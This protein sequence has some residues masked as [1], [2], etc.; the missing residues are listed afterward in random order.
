[1]TTLLSGS[2][3]AQPIINKVE[4]L[5][6]FPTDEP[7]IEKGVSACFA[8]VLRGQLILAGG[9]NF[10]EVPAAQKGTKRFYQGIYVAA[11]D[12]SNSL[13]WRRIGSLPEPLAYGVSL[14]LSDALVL[15]GGQN[16]EGDIQHAYELTLSDGKAE[17]HSL[18][19][20]PV[21]LSN[22][23]GFVLNNEAYVYDTRH[24]VY[25]LTP[26]GWLPAFTIEG[27]RRMQPIAATVAGEPWLWGGFS[28][29]EGEAPCRIH[30]DGISVNNGSTVS[31][32]DYEASLSGASCVSVSPSVVVAT[33]GVNQGVFETQVNTPREGYMLHEPEW[34]R[35]CPAILAFSDGRWKL[36]GESPL[37][38]LAGS[39]MAASGKDIYVIGGELKPGI[40]APR[41]VRIT[42]K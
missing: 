32:P 29:K 2:L 36:I 13:K 38:A 8:G 1:M 31:A 12:G 19:D 3:A 10:P 33:G 39:T 35:F 26:T 22:T 16:A 34:Y 42:L 15:V 28:P 40:R 6:G 24:T 25:R 17:L 21:A 41:V 7:G 30:P 37:T 20:L 5:R 23:A 18:P 14:Q 4:A 9:A 27:P 11:P